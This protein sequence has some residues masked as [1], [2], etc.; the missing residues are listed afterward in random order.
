MMKTRALAFV[1]LLG[2]LVSPT[3]L[4]KKTDSKKTEMENNYN[5]DDQLLQNIL[6]Y[7]EPGP[8]KVI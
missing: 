3:P 1:L 5:G 7:A 4:S 8:A 2:M 6:Q